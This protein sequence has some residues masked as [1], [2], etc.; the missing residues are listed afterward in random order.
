MNKL[1][2]GLLLMLS[3][4]SIAQNDF[5]KMNWG[6]TPEELMSAYPNVDWNI[7]EEGDYLVY[8]A[9]DVVGGLQTKIVYLFIDNKLQTGMYEFQTYHS[10]NN[11]Y[12]EDYQSI[13]SILNKKYDMEEDEN[14]NDTSWKGDKD[15]IGYAL[16]MG[17][18]EFEERYEDQKSMIVHHLTG[19]DG[20]GI[21]HRLVYYSMDFVNAQRA[22]SLDDF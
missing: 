11:L 12:Y 21:D 9:V 14:W 10:A 6:D 4:Q 5:R 18:V 17:H 8:M 19:G 1:V 15:N 20:P 16:R 22:A 2:L 13:S 3:L 7:E